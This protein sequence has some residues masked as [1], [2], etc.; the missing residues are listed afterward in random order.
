MLDPNSYIIRI[1]EHNKVLTEKSEESIQ[2]GEIIIHPEYQRW[3]NDNDIAIIRLK[4]PV[5]MKTEVNV[6][7]LPKSTQDPI[8]NSQAMVVGWGETT[9]TV[10]RSQHSVRSKLLFVEDKRE[11][12]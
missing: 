1:G 4:N 7:C 8:A 6:I 5:A 3:D 12:H 2:A 9:T 10:P 11:S